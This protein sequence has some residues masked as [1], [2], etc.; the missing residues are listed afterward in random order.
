MAAMLAFFDRRWRSFGHAAQGLARLVRGEIHARIH[1]IATMIVFLTGWQMRLTAEDWRW[2]ITACA[3]VWLAEALNT[4]VERL[5]DRVCATHDPA[6]G[7]AKD[8]AAG[9]V[10]VA[11]IAALAIGGSIFLPLL[12]GALR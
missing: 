2:L 7:A 11:A 5:A 8:L 10:L 9:A 4:A 6:I 12:A 3:L 1:L